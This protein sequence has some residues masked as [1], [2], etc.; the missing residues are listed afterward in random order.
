M[1]TV[2]AVNV[3]LHRHVCACVCV[4]EGMTPHLCS[5]SS[6][7]GEMELV[8]VGGTTRDVGPGPTAGV[9]PAVTVVIAVAASTFEGSATADAVVG[10]CIGG[11]TTLAAAKSTAATIA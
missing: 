1:P 9:T 7:E 11:A 5:I 4:L 6:S 10:A 2:I 3:P 8:R